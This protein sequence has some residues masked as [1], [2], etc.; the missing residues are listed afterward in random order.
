MQCLNTLRASAFRLST[1]RVGTALPHINAITKRLKRRSPCDRCYIIKDRKPCFDIRNL[2]LERARDCNAKLIRSFL[3]THYWPRE[4]TVTS[5]WMS[6][7]SPLLDVQTDQY[8][9]SGDR[10]LAYERLERTGERK[11]VGLAVANK[12]YP[13]MIGELDEWA[14]CTTSLPDKYKIYF[15]A[16]CLKGP[17]L[18][19]K[20]NV[21]Y[22]YEVEVLCT[23]AEVTGQ[24]VGKLLLNSMLEYAKEMRHP[25]VQVVAVSHYTS[26]ICEKC[27]MKPEWTMNYE[28]FTDECG[29]RIFF[30]RKPHYSVVVHVKYFD[31][32]KGGV[33]PCKPPF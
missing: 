5:L 7:D 33:L 17:N 28:D 11:L 14:H 27:G 6:L 16:H 23:A 19:K 2:T 12:I 30:P 29:H 25:L 24:G 9:S 1:P 26:K 3:Y 31:P 15:T 10:I 13:W 32:R 4:P 18:F 8:S 21:D 22:I 20:Y